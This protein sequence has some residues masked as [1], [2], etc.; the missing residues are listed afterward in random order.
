MHW[1]SYLLAR[2]QQGMLA[3]CEWPLSKRWAMAFGVCV[4]IV[5]DSGVRHLRTNFVL[6]RMRKTRVKPAPT[7]QN[8]TSIKKKYR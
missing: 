8:T 4:Q 6:A 5:G 2:S 7:R 1:P 3:Q